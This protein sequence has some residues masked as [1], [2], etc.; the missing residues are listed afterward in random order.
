VLYQSKFNSSGRRL[1]F[2]RQPSAAEF[3]TIANH[4]LKRLPKPPGQVASVKSLILERTGGIVDHQIGT[5][6]AASALLL[7]G[8]SMH[9]HGRS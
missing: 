8:F 2:D 1:T 4:L 9:H 6:T 7:R 3:V 5:G